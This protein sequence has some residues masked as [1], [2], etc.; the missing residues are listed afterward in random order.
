[1]AQGVVP[2][3]APATTF[4]QLVWPAGAG[5]HSLVRAVVLAV[6]GSCLLTVSAKISVP[7]PIPIT[8][9]TLA[10]MLLG[11][12]LGARLAVASVLLYLGEGLA[13]MSVFASTPP[14][15]AGPAYLLGPSGGF[16]ASFVGAAALV[17]LAAD[18]GWIR[19]PL[20]FGAALL[21]AEVLILVLGWSWAAFLATRAGGEVG[22]GAARA[23]DLTIRPFLLGDA[24]KLALA[25][26]AF[27]TV[28]E[29]V[30]RLVRR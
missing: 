16:L 29:T 19:K 24:I 15:V 14:A 21:A 26:I 17:G 20:Q 13:G 25:A 22:F 12:V 8:L 5:R 23:F 7:G 18:R 3:Q 11:A 28:Y 2:A 6:L 4:A 10:V 30:S 27:P 1:M 9:Q